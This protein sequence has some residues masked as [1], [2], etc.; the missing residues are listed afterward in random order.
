MP[1]VL[2]VD[3]D[4]DA[5]ETVGAVLRDA[6]FEVSCA[7]TGSD[8]LNTARRRPIDFVV[9]DLW[10]PDMSGLEILDHLRH[11]LKHVPFVVIIDLAATAAAINAELTEAADDRPQF[12]RR[13]VDLL[14]SHLPASQSSAGGTGRRERPNPQVT[15]AMSVIDGRFS[16]AH[17]SVSTIAQELGVSTE[18]LCRL[19]K[20]QTG[21]T[22]VTL[23]RGVRVRTACELLGETTLSMKEIA[24]RAGFGNASRF[25]RDFKKVCGCAPSE[26]RQR[27][28]VPAVPRA[29]I[30][31]TQGISTN[32]KP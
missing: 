1:T 16:D 9:V 8:A 23:L 27:V 26:Y 28:A 2:V 25:A 14:R 32:R 24:D 22:F 4:R 21:H 13:L 11:D 7:A 12:G 10:L 3:D 29:D 5:L 6:G 17:L 30:N 31:F 19:L 20:R 18:H 15:H